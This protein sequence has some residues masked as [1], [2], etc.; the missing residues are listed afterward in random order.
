MEGPMYRKKQREQGEFESFYLAF[1]G[2]LRSDN[3]WV[4]LAKLV[5]WEEIERRYAGL[6]SE[7][8]GAPAISAREAVASLI[9]KEKLGLTDEKTVEQIR[10]NPYLQYLL[11][12]E[13]Y[14][15]EQPF[16][17]SMAGHNG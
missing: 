11:G 2:N 3:R 13:A 8:R 1:G 6:F 12:W 4:R 17:S 7:T 15:D 16:D 14:R 9:I 10:E 5:P